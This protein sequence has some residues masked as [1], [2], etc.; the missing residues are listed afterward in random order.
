VDALRSGDLSKACSPDPTLRE[1]AG[2]DVVDS[3]ELAV[4]ATGNTGAGGK[5]LSYEGPFGVG[6]CIGILSGAGKNADN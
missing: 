2:E 4:A 5:V 6:Y 3:V 1:L